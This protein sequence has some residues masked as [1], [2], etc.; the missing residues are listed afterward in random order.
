MSK[1]FIL[2]VGGSLIVNQ[3]GIDYIWLKKFRQFILQEVKRGSRFFLV[4]GGGLTARQY[5][6]AAKKVIKASTVDCDWVGIEATRLNAL[7]IRV[8]FGSVASPLIVTDPTKAISSRHKIIVA[9]G[10][11]PGWSTDYVA[12]LLAQHN[13]IDKV[14]NLSNIDYAYNKDPRRFKDAQE[15]INV[16]WPEFRQVVGNTWHPGTNTP[17]D[18]IASRL[19]ARNHLSVVILNGGNLQNLG[20]CFKQQSFRGTTIN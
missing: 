17:F 7:L 19:A 13:Q 16:S 4:V 14:I 15:L 9:A 10:Y 18:P 1:V 12:V 8:I 6:Q 3:K 11:K 2:S 5:A 20:R